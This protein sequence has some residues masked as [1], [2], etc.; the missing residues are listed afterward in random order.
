MDWNQW[1]PGTAPVDAFGAAFTNSDYNK[2]YDYLRA[3]LKVGDA[4]AYVSQRDELN[5][6]IQGFANLRAQVYPTSS[7]WTADQRA[8]MYSLPL[9]G[10]VK[11]WEIYQEFQLEGLAQS[12]FGPQSDTRAWYSSY[13]FTVSPFFQTIPAG[14]GIGNGGQIS[15][16][17]HSFVWYQLQLILNNSEKKPN[18]VWPIDWGYSYGTMMTFN[19]MNP[20]QAALMY[21]WLINGLQ[22]Q[23]NGGGPDN[24][25]WA[26]DR[27]NLNVQILQTPE[28]QVIWNGVPQATRAAMTEGFL[29]AWLSQVSGFTPQQF[30]TVGYA[31]A[32]QVPQHGLGAVW[33]G[34]WV[35][36]VWYSIP[37][38][39]YAG[40][41]QTT[42]NAVADWAKKV[43]PLG[44]W[45]ATKTATCGPN[46]SNPAMVV[47]S[48][49]Q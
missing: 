16:D 27:A 42:I 31:A 25:G 46:P 32:N 28:V 21:E 6:F 29:K 3:H 17:Y 36:T 11:T 2:H 33:A 48:T 47:C 23:N 19:R 20:G 39:K 5:Y 40:A 24:G 10:L 30:Y 43:W 38:F 22:I 15:R 37:Q 12:I 34:R 44:N 18:G 8:N 9:W 13:P 7:S 41:S 35:D 1:L 4:T 45:D 26:S 14:P 49:E